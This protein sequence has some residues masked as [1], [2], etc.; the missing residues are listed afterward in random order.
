VFGLDELSQT[1]Q[2]STLREEAELV[3][4]STNTTS[5]ECKQFNKVT[6][7]FDSF[8]LSSEK[9]YLQT[10]SV[11]LEKPAKWRDCRAIYYGP[12]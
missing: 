11:Q 6:E 8:C 12:L 5:E 10:R 9:R 1:K 3:Q 4:V 7:K 2:V